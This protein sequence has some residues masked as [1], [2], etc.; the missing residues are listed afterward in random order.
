MHQREITIRGELFPDVVSVNNV[1][2]EK[3]VEGQHLERGSLRFYWLQ[4][5]SK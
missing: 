4:P 1:E 3:S 5:S 2:R